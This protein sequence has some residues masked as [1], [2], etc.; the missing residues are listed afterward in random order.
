MSPDVCFR[1]S[2]GSLPTSLWDFPTTFTGTLKAPRPKLISLCCHLFCVLPNASTR[3]SSSRQ[4]ACSKNRLRSVGKGER[5]Q[6]L[7]LYCHLL[8]YKRKD[9]NSQPSELEE[10]DIKA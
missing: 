4:G 1:T 10:P 9:F 7:E 8:E 6:K 5:N 2:A 3:V